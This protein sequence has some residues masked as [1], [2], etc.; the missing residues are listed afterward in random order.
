MFLNSLLFCV[1]STVQWSGATSI[2]D[3][4]IFLGGGAKWRRY[5]HTVRH[6]RWKTSHFDDHI[7]FLHSGAMWAL[8]LVVLLVTVA[9]V[10]A[11]LV[12]VLK[13]WHPRWFLEIKSFRFGYNYRIS[14]LCELVLHANIFP[15]TLSNCT[16]AYMRE[17]WCNQNW[18]RKKF[19]AKVLAEWQPQWR[20]RHAVELMR[21]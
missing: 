5:T 18:S 4:I 10:L 7:I 2:C 1:I 9:G 3:G 8:G 19:W 12:Y 13:W 15:P 17:P 6:S 20:V 14:E 21:W 16:T 11:L